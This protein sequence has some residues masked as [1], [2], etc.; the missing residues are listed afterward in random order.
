MKFITIS[1]FAIFATLGLGTADA[2]TLYTCGRGAVH[3][4]RVITEMVAQPPI[5]VTIE[6]LGEPQLLVERAPDQARPAALVTVRLFETMHTGEAFTAHPENFD[7]TELEPG[8]TIDIC[9]RRGQLILAR[10]DGR[11][12]RAGIVRSERIERPKGTQ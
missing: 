12:F 5:V 6:P 1:T 2:Q 9:V 4:V 8:Q 10:G 11:K 7:P 3:T